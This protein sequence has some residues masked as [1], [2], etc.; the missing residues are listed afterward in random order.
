VI[1][2]LYYERDREKKRKLLFIEDLYRIL[3]EV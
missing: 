3:Q 2:R 1:V